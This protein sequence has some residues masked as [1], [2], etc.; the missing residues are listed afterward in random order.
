[1]S[2]DDFPCRNPAERIL[3]LERRSWYVSCLFWI[4]SRRFAPSPD[5]DSATPT[6]VARYLFY[7]GTDHF[8]YFLPLV[9]DVDNEMASVN[10]GNDEQNVNGDEDVEG[11]ND[12]YEEFDGGEDE[13]A[14]DTYEEF[15]GGE[16]EGA[17]ETYEEFD[18]G[19]VEGAEDSRG[20]AEEYNHGYLSTPG[21]NGGTGYSG[22]YEY[23]N[24][25]LPQPRVASSPN[26]SPLD[27]AMEAARSAA[28]SAGE[29]VRS[30]AS[31]MFGGGDGGGAGG[32]DMRPQNL[33]E[34]FDNRRSGGRVRKQAERFSPSAY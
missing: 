14:N 34:E 18:G 7:N 29:T 20:G 11:A 16:D 24:I 17:N 15:D 25:P 12:T 22:S 33:Y 3:K 10:G 4:R 8:D 21:T 30:A 27:R 5:F 31:R 26:G 23:E 13:G 1:M 19:E 9:E 6:G 28:R 2:F 32:G